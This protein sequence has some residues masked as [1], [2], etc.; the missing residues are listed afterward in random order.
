MTN[1]ITLSCNVTID[2]DVSAKGREYIID[3]IG[4]IDE[5]DYNPEIEKDRHFLGVLNKLKPLLDKPDELI[6][7]FLLEFF[8]MGMDESMEGIRNDLDLDDDLCSAVIRP[9]EVG[10]VN[11]NDSDQ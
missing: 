7:L 2:F 9:L 8:K 11:D 10:V 6:P 4:K 5:G 1:K 3:E